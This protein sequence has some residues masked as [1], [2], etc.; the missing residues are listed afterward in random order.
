MVAVLFIV[1]NHLSD[2]LQGLCIPSMVFPASPD[3]RI[4]SIIF[5]LASILPVPCLFA[6]YAYV[7]QDKMKPETLDRESVMTSRPTPVDITHSEPSGYEATEI[8]EKLPEVSPL[9]P[10]RRTRSTRWSALLKTKPSL[11]NFGYTYGQPLGEEEVQP[12][13]ISEFQHAQAPS[14]VMPARPFSMIGSSNRISVITTR[15]G[16]YMI[17]TETKPASSAPFLSVQPS[18]EVASMPYDSA[19]PYNDRPSPFASDKR[20]SFNNTHN[21]TQSPSAGKRRLSQLVE[22]SPGA[23]S[24]RMAKVQTAVRVKLG[25]PAVFSFPG[26]LSQ[27]GTILTPALPTQMSDATPTELS[28]AE[29]CFQDATCNTHSDRP[30]M[31]FAD[32]LEDDAQD[33]AEESDR[34]ISSETFGTPRVERRLSDVSFDTQQEHKEPVV[35]QRKSMDFGKW[36]PGRRSKQKEAEAVEMVVMSDQ[37]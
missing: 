31:M 5:L 9:H 14:Y 33:L 13:S 8:V 10:T 20:L 28:D 16:S 6:T 22:D 27:T 15:P 23:R 1:L 17:D 4:F 19:Q 32:A 24:L 11:T 3:I 35:S 29:N 2:H 18:I 7:H 26:P 34:R 12:D 30:S 37:E 36:L 21:Q 25:G